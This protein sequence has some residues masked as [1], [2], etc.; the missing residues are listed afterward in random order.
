MTCLPTLLLP[1]SLLVLTGCQSVHPHQGMLDRARA[2]LGRADEVQQLQES[3]SK[4]LLSNEERRRYESAGV[5]IEE[6]YSVRGVSLTPR[7]FEA[8]TSALNDVSFQVWTLA[9]GVET[10]VERVENDPSETH[11]AELEQ[12]VELLES[13]LDQWDARATEIL[14]KPDSD[15]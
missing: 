15:H 11:V 13:R 12:G 6:S 10:L 3:T 14:L 8:F 7:E 9:R 4:P 5:E 1:P 2:L